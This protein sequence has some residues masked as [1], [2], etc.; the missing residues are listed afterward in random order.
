[1][2]L[3]KL[4]NITGYSSVACRRRPTLSS[5]PGRCASFCSRYVFFLAVFALHHP[6]PP[7]LRVHCLSSCS[8]RWCV[9]FRPSLS[10]LPPSLSDSIYADVLICVSVYCAN[11]T[12]QHIIYCKRRLKS[13][14][15]LPDQTVQRRKRSRNL[16][17]DQCQPARSHAIL[18]KAE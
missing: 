8:A 5:A 18:S 6:P 1:M 7:P 9:V 2:D 3:C 11:H 16:K 17:E 15:G 10:P 13:T 12:R 4:G 14:S